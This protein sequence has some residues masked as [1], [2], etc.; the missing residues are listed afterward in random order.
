[1]KVN[2]LGCVKVKTMMRR[3]HT[4]ARRHLKVNELG[5]V[6]VKRVQKRLDRSE[7]KTSEIK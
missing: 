5:C 1:M 3:L 2:E 7:E 6:K 4:R